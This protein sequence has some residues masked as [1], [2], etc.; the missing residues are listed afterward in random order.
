M[1]GGRCVGGR[2]RE[3]ESA[4]GVVLR[5]G[6]RVGVGVGT[7]DVS[8]VRGRRRWCRSV[9]GGGGGLWW[10]REVELL[11]LGLF[12]SSKVVFYVFF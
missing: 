1:R 5:R 8:R 4:S 9:G 7:D 6:R 10:S 11:D 12:S 2:C 3:G